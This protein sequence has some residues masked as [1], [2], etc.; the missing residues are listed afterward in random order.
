MTDNVVKGVGYITRRIFCVCKKENRRNTETFHESFGNLLLAAWPH[1]SNPS[2]EFPISS[3]GGLKNCMKGAIHFRV[4]NGLPEFCFSH[5]KPNEPR[6]K[7]TEKTK[8]VP[9][10]EMTGQ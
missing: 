2:G 5:R 7:D 8:P 3:P 10:L 4:P 6:I 1:G 9:S